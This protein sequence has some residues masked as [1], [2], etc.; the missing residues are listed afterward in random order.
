MAAM[1]RARGQQT[2]CFHGDKS[3]RS[4]PYSSW[5]FLEVVVEGLVLAEMEFTARIQSMLASKAE[6]SCAGEM[7]GLGA[8][9]PTV[10][11]NAKVLCLGF[12]TLAVTG[13]AELEHCRKSCSRREGTVPGLFL[14]VAPYLG[15]LHLIPRTVWSKA[16][17]G[18]PR[19]GQ[20]LVLSKQ[21]T[22]VSSVRPLVCSRPWAIMS[23]LRSS[24]LRHFAC[25]P[26]SQ[27]E[28]WPRG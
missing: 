6:E 3:G 8:P 5:D 28:G 20:S 24:V 22:D 21:L 2:G 25:P 14:P 23:H 26:C 18:L 7:S 17:A 9:N 27:I 13:P 10:A 4:S 15:S 16:R 1:I 12:Y 19:S 11:K